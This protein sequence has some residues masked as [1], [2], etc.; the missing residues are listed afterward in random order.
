MLILMLVLPMNLVNVRINFNLSC[1]M[2]E[3][4][5][6]GSTHDGHIVHVILYEHHYNFPIIMWTKYEYL[7][8]LYTEADR[9]FKALAMIFAEIAFANFSNFPLTFYSSFLIS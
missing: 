5:T 8:Q 3:S 6:Y 1:I 2:P 7:Y 9:S 4:L